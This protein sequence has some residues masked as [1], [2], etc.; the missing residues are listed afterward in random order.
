MSSLY[1]KL[2][3]ARDMAANLIKCQAS[4]LGIAETQAITS[5]A[6]CDLADALTEIAQFL[7]I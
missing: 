4:E 7:N 3:N 5:Q 2:N 1:G 6:I